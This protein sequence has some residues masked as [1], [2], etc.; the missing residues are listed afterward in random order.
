MLDVGIVVGF[1]LAFI[2]IG[3]P[4]SIAILASGMF[5]MWWTGIPLITIPI[6]IFNGIKL[7]ELLAV[8]LFIVMG[9]ILTEGGLAQLLV[10]FADSV[11]G[12][13]P[14]GLAMTNTVT[15]MFLAEMS[16]VGT[17]DAAVLAKIFVPT[18]V[19]HGYD[20][21]FAAAVTSA[22]ASL[23]IIIP[24]SLTMIFLGLY[25]DISVAKLFIAG[26]IPGVILGG[27]QLAVSFGVARARGY[28]RSSS[29]N[30]ATVLVSFAKTWFVFLIPVVVLGSIFSGVATVVEAAVM[31]L[32]LT[33]VGGVFYKRLTL[34]TVFGLVK[35]G[36]RISSVVLLIVAASTLVS[37]IFANESVAAQIAGAIGGLH[38]PVWETLLL[39]DVF[40]IV[41][42]TFVHGV[43]AVIIA[44]P[45]FMP[46]VHKIGLDP[47][48]YG[49]MVTM[50]QA[51]GQQTPPVAS[52]LLTVATVSET[53]VEEILPWLALFLVP[54]VVVLA[55]VTFI[56]DVS[57]LLPQLIH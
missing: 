25:A 16:G 9:N 57:I 39:I 53:G 7:Y 3:V 55:L 51:I 24:P 23:G 33:L 21:G 27:C 12:F 10:D 20:R 32:A 15:S 14:G 30:L 31:G 8:P 41:I 56:P 38:I 44:A 19:N 34:A 47:V 46:L 49:I 48:Q 18:M 42:G 36:V 52:V 35:D 22:G 37:W 5:V 1:I 45:I 6:H 2:A 13:F 43:A 50:A 11:V 29:F 40:F 28:S 54:F 4:F 17:A 26:I